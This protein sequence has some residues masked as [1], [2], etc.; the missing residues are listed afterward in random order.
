M[1]V[2]L[3]TPEDRSAVLAL[4]SAECREALTQYLDAGPESFFVLEHPAFGV[5][6]CGG[7]SIGPDRVATLEWGIVRE[8]LR[9]Q[10]LG[11][12]LLLWRLKRI[13]SSAGYV[14]ALVPPA[15]EA[16]YRKN[17]FKPADGALLMKLTVCP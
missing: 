4:A 17:G 11:R 15:F 7:Y 2:R 16:F 13:G 10:G 3:C 9:R 12:Y 14:R 8:D 5:V 1:N 6:A